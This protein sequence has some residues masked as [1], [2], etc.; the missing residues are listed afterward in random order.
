MCPSVELLVLPLFCFHEHKGSL[1]EA[2]SPLIEQNADQ[3][4]EIPDVS[5]GFVHNHLILMIS[6][7]SVSID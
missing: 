1:I 6:C 4:Q 3:V 2:T 5:G 7:N